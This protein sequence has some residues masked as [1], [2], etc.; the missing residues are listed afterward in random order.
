MK[1]PVQRIYLPALSQN[2]R[3]YTKTL[4]GRRAK[5]ILFSLFIFKLCFL[6]CLSFKPCFACHLIREKNS[7][8]ADFH[9]RDKVSSK[10]SEFSANEVQE[11]FYKGE[12]YL[13]LTNIGNVSGTKNQF[14]TTWIYDLRN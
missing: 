10:A 2:F 9:D 4:G 8:F 11:Y 1:A 7:Q 12:D 6:F 13:A 3:P 14:G 5:Y